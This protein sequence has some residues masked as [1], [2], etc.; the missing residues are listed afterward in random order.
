[1]LTPGEIAALP[2][3]YFSGQARWL[4]EHAMGEACRL[5]DDHGWRDGWI[6]KGDIAAAMWPNLSASAQH[7]YLGAL[8]E[9][10]VADGAKYGD[11]QVLT[12]H[13]FQRFDVPS[14]VCA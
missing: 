7:N 6:A 10:L 2:R 9:Y 12:R 13:G 5:F 14:R 4:E 8:L 11:P 3:L 1:M